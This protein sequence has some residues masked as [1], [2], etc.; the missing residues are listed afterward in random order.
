MMWNNVH[1]DKEFERKAT[2]KSIVQVITRT[3]NG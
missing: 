3:L 1:D 2:G